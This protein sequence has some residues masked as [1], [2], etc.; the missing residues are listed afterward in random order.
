MEKIVAINEY[1]AKEDYC[2]VAG[3]EVA[4]T[5]QNIR[6]FINNEA[7]CCESWGYFWCNDNPN[8][9]VGAEL[10]SVSLTDTALNEAQMKLNDL[11]PNDKWFEGGVMFVNLETDR[12]V[13]QF[14]AYNEHNGYYG[15]EATVQCTQLAHSE[16]L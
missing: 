2:E 12:G 1:E 4:T 10:R 8:D 16:Y 6:L 14:V 5:K 3:F 7:S 13:L 11:D 9:F 15:H